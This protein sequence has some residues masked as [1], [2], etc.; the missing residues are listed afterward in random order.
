MNQSSSRIQFPNKIGDYETRATTNDN[1][2]EGKKAGETKIW[3]LRKYNKILD[4]SIFS[5]KFSSKQ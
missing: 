2:F 3:I 1:C 5:Q 4:P